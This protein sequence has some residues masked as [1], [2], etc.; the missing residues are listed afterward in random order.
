MGGALAIP[1]ILDDWLIL[2]FYRDAQS[3][4]GEDHL[5]ATVATTDRQGGLATYSLLSTKLFIP[6]TRH[7]QELLPRPRLVERLQAGLARK[8]TL[9]FCPSRLWQNAAVGRVDSTK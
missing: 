1:Y 6:Q 4:G 3:L 5:T 8:L 9:L 2:Y 7:L